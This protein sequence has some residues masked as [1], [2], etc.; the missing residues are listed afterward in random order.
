MVLAFREFI[1]DKERDNVCL[2]LG[3][4]ITIHSDSYSEG[5]I[6]RTGVPHIVLIISGSST[7][8]I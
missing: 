3:S 2:H 6:G 1:I 8:E 7:E 5:I 4:P